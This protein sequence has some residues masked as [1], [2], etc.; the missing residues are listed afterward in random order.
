MN[1]ARQ[2]TRLGTPMPGAAGYGVKAP[3]HGAV[4]LLNKTG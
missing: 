4:F 1:V 3:D 2:L